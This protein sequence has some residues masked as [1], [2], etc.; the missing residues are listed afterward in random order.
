MLEL[1]LATQFKRDLKKITKQGKRRTLLDSIVEQ[2]QKE[3]PLDPK[4]KDHNLSGNWDGYRECHITPDWLLIY[5]TIKDDRIQ[6]L[7][8][9]RTGSHSDLFG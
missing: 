8:L 2:L 4:H 9:S 6:L 5:K 3:E 1:E 7:R